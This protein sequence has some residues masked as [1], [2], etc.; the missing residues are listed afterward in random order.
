MG[1]PNDVM[2]YM[3][4]DPSIDKLF[5]EQSVQFEVIPLHAPLESH[6]ETF[7][8]LPAPSIYEDESTIQI[9]IQI[10]V[11]NLTENMSMNMLIHILSPLREQGA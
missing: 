7:V 11:L 4:I 8:P 6:A 9:M 1:Y 3:L 2:G 5:I 10:W